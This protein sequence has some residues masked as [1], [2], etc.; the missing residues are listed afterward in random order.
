MSTS[1]AFSCS[2]Q[3]SSSTVNKEGDVRLLQGTSNRYST[4]QQHTFV[5]I[6]ERLVLAH[7]FV[8]LRLHVL[9][10]I[11]V[12]GEGTIKLRLEHGRVLL[13]LGEFFLQCFRPEHR[14][15]ISLE[16]LRFL[17]GSVHDILQQTT[18][19]TRVLSTCG[20]STIQ[21]Y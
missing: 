15:A 7:Q 21:G 2:T 10:F 19:V 8:A 5:L 13:G 14:I 9:D 11:M 3:V 6:A 4:R 16:H 18:I 17:S 12:L 1:E 20:R